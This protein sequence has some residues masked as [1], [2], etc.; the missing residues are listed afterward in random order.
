VSSFISG[1]I[2]FVRRK[3]SIRHRFNLQYAKHLWEGLRSIEDLPRYSVITG[4]TQFFYPAGNAR[5]LDLGCGEGVLQ[6]RLVPVGYAY[7]LGVDISDVAIE[8]VRKKETA[9]TR[10]ATGNLDRPAIEGLYDVAIYNE[11]IYYLKNPV[12]AVRALFANIAPGG[13]FIISCYNRKGKEHTDLWARLSEV[14]D[15]LDSTKV[16]NRNGD[17]WTIHVYKIK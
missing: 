7:Y 16:I 10:F 15:L 11:S 6:E 12:A 17:S 14:L 13:L 9:N 2:S 3:T 1:I 5:I 8:N 4:Y